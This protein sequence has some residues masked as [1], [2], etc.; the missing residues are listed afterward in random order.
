MKL[1][2]LTVVRISCGANVALYGDTFA[3]ESGA[4]ELRSWTTSEESA[5]RKIDCFGRE[6]PIIVNFKIVNTK[7]RNI[8]SRLNYDQSL[9]W[10]VGRLCHPASNGDK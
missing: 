8:V 4:A 5:N 6:N 7:W 10:P 2:S 3:P 1:I 9:T